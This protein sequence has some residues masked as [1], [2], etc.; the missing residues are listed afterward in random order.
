[1][2]KQVSIQT[3][4]FRKYNSKDSNNSNRE[5]SRI[6]KDVRIQTKDNPVMKTNVTEL[7]TINKKEKVVAQARE[8]KIPAKR[9]PVMKSKIETSVLSNLASTSSPI[10]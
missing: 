3:S 7:V 6:R 8:V 5:D 4:L 9:N 10:L 2:K 1:M